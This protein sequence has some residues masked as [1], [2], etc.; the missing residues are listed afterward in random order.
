[1]RNI[2][3]FD[4]LTALQIMEEV[5]AG[6]DLDHAV[7]VALEVRAAADADPWHLEPKNGARLLREVRETCE[8]V[9]RRNRLPGWV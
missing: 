7:T 3:T 8:R 4:F 2:E 6:V 1:M 9:G 5:E